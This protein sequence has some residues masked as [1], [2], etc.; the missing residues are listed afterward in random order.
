MLLCVVC[1]KVI[2][3]MDNGA[4]VRY[5]GC[6]NCNLKLVAEKMKERR[7]NDEKNLLVM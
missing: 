6:G 3:N 5:G 2:A 4:V 7:Q 1:G